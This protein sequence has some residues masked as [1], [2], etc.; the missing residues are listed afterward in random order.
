MHPP[1]PLVRHFQLRH[2]RLHHSVNGPEDARGRAWYLEERTRTGMSTGLGPGA[3]DR[4]VVVVVVVVKECVSVCL[5]VKQAVLAAL[6]CGYRHI[7]CAAAY[8]NE[9]EVGE[10]LALRVGAGKVRK[11]GREEAPSDSNLTLDGA[12]WCTVFPPI[13]SPS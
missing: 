8:G 5:Q 4:A 9:Q 6:D 1:D 2:E 10:A 11:R 12:F 13:D 7:D 3:E